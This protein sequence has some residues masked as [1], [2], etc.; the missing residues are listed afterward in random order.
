MIMSKNGIVD[1]VVSILR[2]GFVDLLSKVEI[3][4]K[5]LRHLKVEIMDVMAAS[6]NICFL[7]IL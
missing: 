4:K 2:S 5:W 1:S 6:A 3:M 7:C